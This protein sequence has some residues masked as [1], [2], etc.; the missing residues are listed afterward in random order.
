MS[1][2]KSAQLL[3]VYRRIGRLPWALGYKVCSK[4]FSL[5]VESIV[6]SSSVSPPHYDLPQGV[7][8]VYLHVVLHVGGYACVCISQCVRVSVW[9]TPAKFQTGSI[10]KVRW[11]T[12]SLSLPH[13]FFA[14]CLLQWTNSVLC[15]SGR[16][17]KPGMV[18]RGLSC[19]FTASGL[20]SREEFLQHKD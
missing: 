3:C 7:F 6:I 9:C 5:A 10:L 15:V 4:S 12:F 16:F 19:T 20:L 2:L 17:R 11:T 14:L 8:S 13:S 1:G 18:Q